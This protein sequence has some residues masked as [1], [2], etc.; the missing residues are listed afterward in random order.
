M[1]KNSHARWSFGLLGL[2][3]TCGIGSVQA[4]TSNT[5]RR[6]TVQRPA[7]RVQRV[8]VVPRR[9]VTPS[10]DPA[11]LISMQ[12]W[13]RIV[14]TQIPT[15]DKVERDPFAVQQNRRFERGETRTDATM[16]TF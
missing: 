7:S 3:L 11:R 12:E 13:A 10:T 9:A 5:A 14:R 8:S 4:A 16:H 1:K 15:M 6:N 2:F